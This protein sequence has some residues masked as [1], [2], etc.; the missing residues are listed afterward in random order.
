LRIHGRDLLIAVVRLPPLE[1][2]GVEISTSGLKAGSLFKFLW[3]GNAF[4]LLPLHI[5]A[6]VAAMLVAGTVTI[7]QQPVRGPL[8]LP[9]A[10]VMWP[11]FAAVLSCLQWV[12]F[13]FGFWLYS[14][15]GRLTLS[16]EDGST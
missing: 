7:N 11:I 10:L 12:V 2:N 13:A 3:L 8:A 9:A 4:G 5:I 1:E 6:G 14:R 16:F 15:W